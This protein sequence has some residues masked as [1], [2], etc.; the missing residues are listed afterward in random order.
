MSAPTVRK[1]IT[2][3]QRECCTWPAWCRGE[4]IGLTPQRKPGRVER[5]RVFASQIRRRIR[6]ECRFPV[7]IVLQL[8]GGH[9]MGGCQRLQSKTQEKYLCCDVVLH[10]QSSL[11]QGVEEQEAMGTKPQTSNAHPTEVLVR[12]CATLHARYPVSVRAGIFIAKEVTAVSLMG[13]KVSQHRWNV[14]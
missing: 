3:R 11:S 1:C 12:K 10:H 9:V 14:L 8:H 13:Q 4:R 5:N 6:H 7:L 2:K